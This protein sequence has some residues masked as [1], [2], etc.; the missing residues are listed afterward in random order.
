MNGG[1]IF[2]HLS[3]EKQFPEKRAKFYVAEIILALE[4][5]HSNNIIYWDLKPENVLLDCEGH[6]K[7]T[8]FGLS[9]V[10]ESDTTWTFAGTPEYLAPEIVKAR[11]YGK[12]VD[13]WSLGCIL[14]EMLSGK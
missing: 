12:E 4:C 10:L 2:Y 11:T 13:W 9:K 3:K 14:F 1:E 6:I 5:L 7:L 8:D